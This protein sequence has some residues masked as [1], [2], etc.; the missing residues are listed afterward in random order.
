MLRS[1]TKPYCWRMI[2]HAPD[3]SQCSRM[4]R[5]GLSDDSCCTT[6]SPAAESYIVCELLKSNHRQGHSINNSMMQEFAILNEF[7][8]QTVSSFKCARARQAYS[9]GG[10]HSNRHKISRKLMLQNKNIKPKAACITSFENITAFR[11]GSIASLRFHMN[12][13]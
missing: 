1:E 5:A 9:P 2:S 3:C 12:D 11:S 8:P 6:R 10:N 4:G 13:S 7:K